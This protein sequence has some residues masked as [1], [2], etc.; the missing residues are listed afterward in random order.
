MYIVSDLQIGEQVSM[1]HVHN[2]NEENHK[3]VN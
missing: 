3:Y 1:L 2:L